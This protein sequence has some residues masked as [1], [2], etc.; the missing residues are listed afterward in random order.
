MSEKPLVTVL[1]TA[2]NNPGY[3]Y[4]AIRSALSQDYGNLEVLVVDDGSD[5]RLESTVSR[6]GDQRV[7]YH[8][9]LHRGLPFGL[10]R[11]METARGDYVAILDHDDLLTAN[12]IARRAAILDADGGVSF[13]YGDI[14]YINSEGQVYSRQDFKTYTGYADFLHA[15]LASP[16]GPVKHSG[17]MFRRECVLAVGNYNPAYK[18]LY[19]NELLLRLAKK[20]PF[21]HVKETVLNYRTHKSNATKVCRMRLEG[22]RSEFRFINIHVEKASRRMLYRIRSVTN[23]LAKVLFE[24]FFFLKP[25]WLLRIL[26][27]PGSPPSL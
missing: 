7:R 5:P 12:S 2:Y 8:F 11:G 23:N 25:R 21:A 15:I 24:G 18:A 3:L 14:N 9:M 19:D 26:G 1:I 16:V 22:I 6:I 20:Y 10:I 17:I 4:L 27:S 13:V